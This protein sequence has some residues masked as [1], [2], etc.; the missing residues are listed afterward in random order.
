[1]NQKKKNSPSIY[2]IFSL[3]F[4]LIGLQE[5]AFSQ[6]KTRPAPRR[7]GVVEK[8]KV[9]SKEDSLSVNYKEDTAINKGGRRPVYRWKDRQTN[10]YVE[11]QAHSPLL[12]KDSKVVKNDYKLDPAT[13][14]I[15]VYERIGTYQYR[16]PQDLSFNQYSSIQNRVVR[17]SLLREYAQS[18]DGKS[19]VSGRGL[20]PLISKSKIADKIFGGDGESLFKPNGFVTIDMGVRNEFNDNP[21]YA[22]SLRRQRPFFFEPQINFSVNGKVGEKLGLLTNFDTKSTFNFENQL[23]LNYKSDP[24]NILQKFEAGNVTL[25]LQSQLIPGVQN[26]FG[27]KTTLKFGKTDVQIVAAQQR[28]RTETIILKAGQQNK[29]F[30]VRCDTYDEN[31]HFFLSQFFRENYERSLKNLPL[32]TSGV[33][34]TRVEVYVTNRSNSYETQRNIVGLADLGEPNPHSA[35]LRKGKLNIADNKVSN[36]LFDKLKKN[37]TFRTV[38]QTNSVLSGDL[39]LKRNE[40]YELLRGAKRLTDRDFRFNPDLGYISLLSQLR[41]DE[42]LAVAYEYTYNGQNYKVGELMEDYSVL[43]EDQVVVLKLLKTSTIRNR[44][45]LPMWNLMM[46]NVYSLPTAGINRQGFQLRLIYKDDQ[47]GMDTPSLQ[48]GKSTKDVPLVQM[49]N[50]DKLNSQNDPQPDGNFDFV[51][52]VTI[53]SKNGKVYFPTLEPFGKSLEKF[54]GADEAI[55]KDKYIYNELYRG[56]LT[57]A[58]QI[59]TK[60][61]FFLRGNYQ[62]GGV[63]DVQLPLGVDPKSV[64]VMA[65]GNSLMEGTDFQVDGQ[66]GRLR[67]TNPAV[68]NSAREVRIEYEKPEIFMNQSRSL[69]GT[70]IDHNLSK[71]IHIGFT[72]MMMRESPPSFTTRVP[73]GQEPVNNSIIGADLTLKKD[74]RWLTRMLDALPFVQTKE[75]SVIQ[76]QG[77]YA[78]LFPG[79]SPKIKTFADNS[80]MIDEFEAARNTYDLA[81]QPNRWRLGSTPINILEET[82]TE[83]KS[84]ASAY[85]RAKMSVYRMDD[86]FYN[87]GDGI[88]FTQNSAAGEGDNNLYERRFNV[89]DIFVN[90]SNTQFANQ[91][92]LINIDFA[93][94]PH[95]RGMYNYN[96]DLD[97][98]GLLKNPK[99]NYGAVMRAVSA[100]NDFDNSN[101]ELIEFWMLNPFKD[102]V[103]DGIKNARNTTGGKLKIQLGDIS[104]DVIP[105]EQNNFENGLP[106][107]TLI[108]GKTY[109]K[110]AWGRAPKVQFLIDAFSNTTGSREKQDVGLEGLG[111]KDE[112]KQAHIEEFIKKVN[113][114]PNITKEAKDKILKDPS[115]DDF[116]FYLDPSF[117]A[118]TDLGLLR[119]YKDYLGMENNSPVSEAA[120]R[121]SGS[122]DNFTQASTVQPDKEDLNID[123][124]INDNEAFYEYELDLKVN[125]LG[126]NKGYVVDKVEKNGAEWLLFRVPI[127]G[128]TRKVGDING[129]KSIRFARMVMTDWEQPVV[130][131]MASFQL[132]GNSYRIYDKDLDSRGLTEIPEP[133]DAQFKIGVVNIEENGC[134]PLPDGTTNCDIK[135]DSKIPYL[136]PPGFIRDRDVNSQFPVFFNEQS[137][138]LSVKNLRDND[139]RAAFKNGNYN[140]TNYE[141]L[142]MFIHMEN[143][144][145]IS[146]QVSAFLRVGTDLSEN[147][148][149]IEVPKLQATSAGS[150]QTPNTVWPKQ[151]S[152]DVPIAELIKTKSE[153]NRQ[154]ERGL[155]KPYSRMYAGD[156]TTY[157]LTVVGNPDLSSV[158]TLMIGVRN[159]KSDD[160]LPQTFTIWVNELRVSGFNQTQGEAAIGTASIKLADLGNVVMNGNWR[161]FG[162]GGVQERVNQRARE[163]TLEFGLTANVELDKFLPQKW[164]L[165]IPLYITSDQSLIKPHFNPLDPDMPLEQTLNDIYD[166]KDTERNKGFSSEERQAL[167]AKRDRYRSLVEEKMTRKGFNFTNVRKIRGEEDTKQRFYDIENFTASYAQSKQQRSSIL[168]DESVS[169]IHK[170]GFSYNYTF[171]PKSFEPFAK[172]S[173]L[174]KPRYLWLKDFN[175]A[176]MPTVIAFRTDFDRMYS[177]TQFRNSDLTTQGIIPNYEKYF[178]MN[179]FYDAQWNLTKTISLS[180][181]G[182][183]NAIIDEPYGN[184]KV[185]LGN[186]QTLINR[187]DSVLNSLRRLGRAKL[188]DQKLSASYQI[189]L[190]KLYIMD[191]MQAQAVANTGFKYQASSFGLKDEFEQLFGNVIFNNRDFGLQGR[192]DLVKLYNKI[193]YLK[194]AN[195]PPPPRKNFARSPGDDEELEKPK[196]EALRNFTRLLMAVRGIQ[197]NTGIVETTTLPGFMPSPQILGTTFGFGNEA[198]APGLGFSMLGKQY[199]DATG[200]ENFLA[201]AAS[202]GW[203]SKS[204]TQPLPFIQTRVKKFDFSTNI[205]PI[206]DLKLQIRGQINRGDNYQQIYR[207]DSLGRYTTS[208]PVRSGQFSMS[209]WSFKTSFVQFKDAFRNKQK[210]QD[211]LGSILFDNLQA[212]R[213]IFV[214]KLTDGKG[215]KGT[216]DKNSQDVLIPAF[217]AAYTGK[218]PNKLKVGSAKSFNPFLKFPMPNWR[219]DYGKLADLKPFKKSFTSIT[220]SHSYAST[221]SVGNF[222]SSLGYGQK[223]VNLA[224]ND[225]PI[226]TLTNEDL[227]FIPV[228]VMSSIS[229]QEKFAP[230][231]GVQF[232]TKKNI[233]GRLEYNQERNVALN[234]SNS[235]I[236]EL[237]N[238][239]FVFGVGYKKNKLKLPFRINGETITLKNDVMVRLDW[240]IRDSGL[241]Q[242]KLEDGTSLIT[243]GNFNNIFRYTVDYQFNKNVQAKFYIDYSKNDPKTTISYLR[244]QRIIG[245][246]LRF[247]LADLDSKK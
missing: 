182:T 161:T 124:T 119:R 96:P 80:V 76:I 12:M 229:M 121:T 55:L 105:D 219:L 111:N 53:D 204:T 180:Y 148:Y 110:T 202:N 186:Q 93:Y 242:R 90:R 194:F 61:K 146:G 17:Q 123:N 58:Q 120:T 4:A 244:T 33:R 81:R 85:K 52:G 156:S 238:R 41:N 140:L 118:S 54:F 6:A 37:N 158:Q 107:D 9:L 235:T 60:N 114:I 40:D 7:K 86:T 106:A 233:S 16:S 75:M 79:V 164:N 221:Y 103:R 32:I 153:R 177:K 88:G 179:R 46:K 42:V 213:D 211:E 174:D 67:I 74:A 50:L 170:G 175:I 220:L 225:Y 133:Y 69:Y 218:D 15:G 125:T 188:F 8:P 169:D 62:S 14:T 102:V 64:R 35:T 129:F 215:E 168:I 240:T 231:I 117:P 185:V 171:S 201:N 34:V 57:D 23:R 20:K 22:L 223:L 155:S 207:I 100:D 134:D 21:S 94:F 212:Y 48:E 142:K 236:A 59:T 195:T 163:N 205:E 239:D 190:E 66:S 147:Y 162:F 234:V 193:R 197:F 116:R 198:A 199:R 39:N 206:K 49:F 139:S 3:L 227:Q 122:G 209:F 128:Y 87:N 176:P 97:A 191:W 70:R 1:M 222:T 78:R 27:V 51:E 152:I 247:N 151:N 115:A 63:N 246:Q 68:L 183:M 30:E 160:E 26:L 91:A 101:I 138:T 145:D 65:G 178:L 82:N 104:E 187:R 203:L 154:L 19:A 95:E 136:I 112:A 109:R 143:Q 56:T 28:S 92:P 243:Q 144:G 137:M 224:V 11:P 196:N 45:D 200:N 157:K 126:L 38:D 141:S 89:Q 77:E 73:I 25:P 241:L 230:F 2:L 228:F 130:V 72:A 149:E 232:T 173:K 127:R 150:K 216:Y 208:T 245:I 98:N 167:Q 217:F 31:R 192:I 36:D 132:V 24:E 226:A 159:P 18:S 10:R 131:R 5:E 99:Q 113:A 83:R 135:G 29:G 71:D 172:S 184:D 47:T 189:P 166:S 181:N 214:K 43:T 108:E 84:I 44:L 237:S 165:K 210:K 13:K